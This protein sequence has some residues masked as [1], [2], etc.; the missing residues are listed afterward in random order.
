MTMFNILLS[1]LGISSIFLAT[2]MGSAFVFFLK[3]DLGEKLNSCILGFAGGI[4]FSACIFGLLLP[5][6]E[7]TAHLGKLSFLPVAGGLTLGALLLVAIDKICPFIFKSKTPCEKLTKNHTS[8]LIAITLH[9]I[10]EG[11]IVGLAFGGALIAG[12]KAAIFSALILSVGIALQNIPEGMAVSFPLK[13]DVGNKKAFFMGV[14]SGVVEPIFAVLGLILATQLT[15]LMPIFLSFAAGIMIFVT[16]DDLVPEAKF[17]C[18]TRHGSLSF[19]FGF[20]L[21][22]ILELVLG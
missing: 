4:M 7:Q 2:T 1:I 16:V 10:P 21:M 19:I 3:R 13:K 6:I 22:L 17:A 11:L 9:N 15:K 12:T 8:F 20:I 5:A 14:L 18:P